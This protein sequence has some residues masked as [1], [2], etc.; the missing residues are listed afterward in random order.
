MKPLNIAVCVKQVPDSRHWDK[1]T[2]DSRTKALQREGIPIMTSPLDLNALEEALKIKESRGGTITAISMGP[3]N[4]I[5][6]LAWAYALGADKAVLLTDRAFAGADTWATAHALAAGFKKLGTF[7]LIF[8]GNKSLDGSTGQVPP[9]L[10]EFLDIAH[11]INVIKLEIVSDTTVHATY[12]AEDEFVKVE[13]KMPVLLAVEA[14]IN[15]PRI[16]TAF[17]ALWATEKET[18]VWSADK[19]GVDRTKIGLSGSRTQVGDVQHVET[20]RHSEIIAGD[21]ALIAKTLVEKLQAAGIIH[22]RS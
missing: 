2:L 20:K 18:E 6:I 1:I 7:D 9:Q 3:P 17:G 14:E 21:P 12:W 5:E 16:P 15:T 19:I 8:L 10:A 4:T 13:V 11:V 22:K